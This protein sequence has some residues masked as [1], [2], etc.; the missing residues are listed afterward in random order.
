MSFNK[1]DTCRA[2]TTFFAKKNVSSERSADNSGVSHVA[3]TI[4][5]QA[6]ACVETY[7]S[8]KLDGS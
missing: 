5:S 8:R 4:K 7:V 6:E 3:L 2:I 1:N